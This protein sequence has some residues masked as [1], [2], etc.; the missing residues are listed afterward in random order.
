MLLPT[1]QRPKVVPL[2]S[3]PFCPQQLALSAGNSSSEMEGK[4][5]LVH[6]LTKPFPPKPLQRMRDDVK[7]G[8]VC[9]LADTLADKVGRA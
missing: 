5:G 1:A 2:I 6:M 8:R 4:P 3:V 7:L 9:K